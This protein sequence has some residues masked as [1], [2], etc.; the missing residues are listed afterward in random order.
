MRGKCLNPWLRQLPSAVTGAFILSLTYI[1]M[2]SSMFIS[3]N[4]SH[5]P[6]LSD[7]I[8]NRLENGYARMLA[9]AL[10]V[11]KIMV[12]SAF[13]LFGVAVFLFMQMGGEFIP[14][15]EEGDFATETRLL[16]GTNLSTTIDAFNRISE[17]LKSEYPEVLNIVSRI[18]SAEIPTDPMPIEG[19]DMIIVL[20]DKSEWSSAKTFPELASKMA[21]SAQQVIPGVTTGFQY[22]VQMRF[23]ELMTGAK[24]DVVCKIFGED[25]DKLAA[26]AEQLGDISK[27]VKGTADWY[28]EKVTGMPQVVIE[29]NR[30]E[31]A[32]YGMNIDDINRTIN[33]AFA[34]A[35]AGQIYEGEKKFDL[36]VRVGNEGRRNINDVQNLLISTP[37]GIQIPLYQV[38]SIQEIEGPNQIQREN[39]RRRIIVGFNVRGRDV[40]SIVEE[41]QKKWMCSLNLKLVIRSLM[42][43]HLKIYSRPKQG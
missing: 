38:A 27:S 30:D 16:V 18:G 5:K 43:V 23:N 11:K 17:R 9:G 25:L 15:L 37:S 35:A 19:G 39:T 8:M 26:Y 24:Q 13:T 2:I 40:Q 14:Q 33:A 21:E 12:L 22:P 20:K 28:I 34:G 41:L 36:V 42:V 31:I 3:K 4:I 1:P 32:K 7:Q 29:F 10:R 6:N